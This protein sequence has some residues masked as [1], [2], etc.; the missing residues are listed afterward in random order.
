MCPFFRSS[1]LHFQ[2]DVITGNVEPY[3]NA[4]Y[5]LQHCYPDSLYPASFIW[6]YSPNESVS[7]TDWLT[8]CSVIECRIALCEHIEA[9][10][11]QYTSLSLLLNTDCD[12]QSPC[13]FTLNAFSV[14]LGDNNNGCST[15]SA[16]L[17]N[18]LW[19]KCFCKVG[20]AYCL[21][22][23]LGK[24]CMCVFTWVAWCVYP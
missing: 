23:I 20:P 17:M 22:Q 16:L 2:G 12:A 15:C 18:H 7:L 9:W 11:T 13:T 1:V 19:C 14:N 6:S 3:W 4:R 10:L 8:L 24:Y 5:V 21:V